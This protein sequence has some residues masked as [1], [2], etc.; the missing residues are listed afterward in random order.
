MKLDFE[1]ANW[2][3]TEGER[4]VSKELDRLSGPHCLKH[5]DD[6]TLQVGR[7]TAQLDHLVVDRDG[8]V[9]IESKV[10][11]GAR[12]RGTDVEKRWTAVYHKSSTQTFQNP[13]AQNREHENALRQA[14]RQTQA[15]LDPDYIE[16]VV[17]FVGA[18]LSKL[19]LHSSE[20]ERVLTIGQL[21]GYFESRA[22][23]SRDR[24]P[25]TDE[26]IDYWF[27]T[28]A[29]LNKSGDPAV[30]QQHA[31]YR[32]GTSTTHGGAPPGASSRAVASPQSPGWAPGPHSGTSRSRLLPYVLAATLVVLAC[33]ASAVGGVA[34]SLLASWPSPVQAPAA[35]VLAPA[36]AAPAGD[37]PQLA[38]ARLRQLAPDV[39]D[40]VTDLRAPIVA[41]AGGETTYTWHYLVRVKPNAVSVREFCLVLGPDGEMRRMGAGK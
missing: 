24:A 31:A 6:V 32:R 30:R 39:Y 19:E 7:M 25:W 3:G 13:L 18:D 26:W 22:L 9:I 15:T 33:G 4:R 21:E 5:L 34:K 1:S 23:R 36:S 35:G 28:I 10:R 14:L 27:N 41:R 11:M 17:V 37:D 8:I 12:I 16:S 2:I 38:Q 40:A 29:W 20:R